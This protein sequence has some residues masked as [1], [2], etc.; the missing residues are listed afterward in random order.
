MTY[1]CDSCGKKF[2]SNSSFNTHMLRLHG[3]VKDCKL[4]KE[5]VVKDDFVMQELKNIRH[6]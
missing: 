6:L 1:Y 4:E 3:G 5:F 2:K